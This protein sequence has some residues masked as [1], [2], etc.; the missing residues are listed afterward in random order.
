SFS[1]F[2]V[3]DAIAQ[4]DSYD[5]A[6]C[7]EVERLRAGR[8]L[9]AAQWTNAFLRPPD[10]ARVELMVALSQDPELADE[11]FS[12]F[13]RRELQWARVG[14]AQRIHDWLGER[15]QSATHGAALA[16]HAVHGG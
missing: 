9:A 11:Y 6:F 8:V 10:E 16:M 4:A 13:G 12:N 15:Q 3:A 7:H 1:A 5:L 14:S 2:A